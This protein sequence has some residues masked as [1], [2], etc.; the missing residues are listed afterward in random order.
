MFSI[1]VNFL[2]Y[3]NNKKRLNWKEASFEIYNNFVSV[4]LKNC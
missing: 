3:Y 4:G 1:A 2:Q